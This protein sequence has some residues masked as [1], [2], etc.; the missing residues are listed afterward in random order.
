MYSLAVRAPYSNYWL[1]D[2][3]LPGNWPTFWTTTTKGWTGMVRV[4]GQ[5]YVF[6]GNPSGLIGLIQVGVQ[7][8]SY[9]TPTQ[10]IF[11]INVGLIELQVTF[12]SPV[13]T[14]DIRRQSIPLSYILVNAR[15][16]DET[17]HQVEVYMDISGEWAS[18]D[19]QNIVTWGLTTGN[20]VKTW[21]VSMLNQ[22]HFSE[23]AD[24]AQV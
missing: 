17:T 12:I 5:A 14:G 7:K 19:V 10:T 11:V 6:M 22:L 1:C 3:V 15:S 18:S 2:N 21:S 9:I 13:E 23:Y 20:S 8:A 4:D 24:Y 16:T